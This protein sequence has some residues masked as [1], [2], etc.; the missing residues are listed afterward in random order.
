MNSI[1]AASK[2]AMPPAPAELAPVAATHA[3]EIQDWL[4]PGIQGKPL[5]M[6]TCEVIRREIESLVAGGAKADW[7]LGLATTMAAA[8][9]QGVPDPEA[10]RIYLRLA[11][12]VLSEYPPAIGA[13]AVRTL[14]RSQKFR[15]AISEIHE[16]CREERAKWTILL[17]GLRRMG[18]RRAELDAEEE[19]AIRLRRDA[20]AR[21]ATDSRADPAPATGSAAA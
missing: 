19:R 13:A 12:D 10:G 9:P 5:P 7:S 11:A 2:P 18:D 4:R 16:A 1:V 21:A 17:I 15:P 3:V 14:I 8:W 20:E 6:A